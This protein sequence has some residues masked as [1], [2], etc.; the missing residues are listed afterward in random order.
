METK[1]VTKV[2]KLI[3]FTKPCTKPYT[4]YTFFTKPDAKA[5]N[6]FPNP[7]A[8]TLCQNHIIYATVYAIVYPR[9]YGREYSSVCYS[10]L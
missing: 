5:L 10:V 8:K 1:I 3:Y 9:V 6:T 4:N 2:T 7:Y